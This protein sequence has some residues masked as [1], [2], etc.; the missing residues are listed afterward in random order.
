LPGSPVGRGH[1]RPFL[2]GRAVGRDADPPGSA[3]GAED[4]AVIEREWIG[5]PG[6]RP[7]VIEIGNQHIRINR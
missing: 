4:I 1:L 2:P 5:L 7:M 6:D 3:Q